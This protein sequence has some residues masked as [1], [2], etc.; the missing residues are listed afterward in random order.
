MIDG[1]SE[2]RPIFAIQPPNSIR[3]IT[4][5]HA[6]DRQ[7]RQRGGRHDAQQDDEQ[8]STVDTIELSAQAQ[9]IIQHTGDIPGENAH[10]EPSEQTP[11]NA[12]PADSHLDI[13]V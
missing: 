7:Q 6:H 9:S 4:E 8:E 11:T 2:I 12:T 5:Q 10:S 13:S 1:S 3:P